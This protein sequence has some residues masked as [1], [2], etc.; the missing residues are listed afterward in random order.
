MLRMKKKLEDWLLIAEVP[1]RPRSDLD[2]WTWESYILSLESLYLAQLYRNCEG[3]QE[4][5]F[6]N[7]RNIGKVP[8]Q[9]REDEG[10]RIQRPRADCSR[11][12][13][14]ARDYLSD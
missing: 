12:Q 7:F 4:A 10:P 9:R 2:R 8:Y 5:A 13:T 1:E 11:R 6:Q 14:D 3:L